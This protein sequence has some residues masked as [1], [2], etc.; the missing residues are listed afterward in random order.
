MIRTPHDN[1]NFVKVTDY[2]DMTYLIRACMIKL[3]ILRQ[4]HTYQRVK[5]KN[6]VFTSELFPVIHSPYCN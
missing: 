4:T 3:Y 2:Y 5:A 1:N 6:C